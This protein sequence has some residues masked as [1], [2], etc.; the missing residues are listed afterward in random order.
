MDKLQQSL[1]ALSEVTNLSEIATRR[2]FVEANVNGVS[3]FE[4]DSCVMWQGFIQEAYALETAYRISQLSLVSQV[5]VLEDSR[6]SIQTECNDTASSRHE[7][8]AH[9]G[10]IFV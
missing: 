4:K 2:S 9:D 6:V 10:F 1:A 3:L 7:T 5:G 8:L